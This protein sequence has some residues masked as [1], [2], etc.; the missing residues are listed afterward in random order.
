MDTAMT[1][2]VLAKPASLFS[3]KTPAN[4][5]RFP[6]QLFRRDRACFLVKRVSRMRLNHLAEFQIS[7]NCS[8][9][10]V[11]EPLPDRA[12]LSHIIKEPFGTSNER[13]ILAIRTQTQIHSIQV[14]F[15]RHARECNDHQLDQT[16]ISF[17][18][19]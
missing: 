13:T 9:F 16:R 17:V 4:V 5:A 10:D 18:T 14:T 2:I 7:G 8:Q 15:A 19:G 3:L 1:A 6:L 12:A 11:G